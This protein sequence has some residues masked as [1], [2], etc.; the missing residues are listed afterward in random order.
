MKNV[1][2]IELNMRNKC[3]LAIIILVPRASNPFAH[4]KRPGSPGDEDERSW[5]EILYSP[6]A[7][8]DYNAEF[9]YSSLKI[10][11]ILGLLSP[12]KCIILLCSHWT[13][14]VKPLRQGKNLWYPG[15]MKS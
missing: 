7:R 11:L 15:F 13:S 1:K 10:I 6:H 9:L 12:L 4:L 8:G 3:G 5:Q 14:N 2:K